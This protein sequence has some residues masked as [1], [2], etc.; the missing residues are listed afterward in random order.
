MIYANNFEVPSAPSWSNTS[1]ATTPNGHNFLGRFGNQTI[2]LSLAGIADHTDINLSFDLFLIGTW[3]GKSP[4][5]G[6]PDR[7]RVRADGDTLLDSSFSNF[8]LLKQD[9]PNPLG[10]GKLRLAAPAQP[11]S[12]LA[13][14]SGS[15][16]FTTLSSALPMPPAR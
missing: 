10:S 9:F 2:T 16:A 11:A 5:V 3:D 7:I 1:T 4:I 13:I 14:C 15:T 6:G 12:R 8:T